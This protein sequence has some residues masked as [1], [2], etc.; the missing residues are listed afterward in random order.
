M[1]RFYIDICLPTETF[2]D[3]EGLDFEDFHEAIMEAHAAANNLRR[4]AAQNGL[5]VSGHVFT[6]RD[7]GAHAVAAISFAGTVH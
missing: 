6:V 2:V 3:E 5:D 7:A 4:K 1:A